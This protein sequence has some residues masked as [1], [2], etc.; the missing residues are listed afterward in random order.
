MPSNDLDQ[1]MMPAGT[2][3]AFRQSCP[4]ACETGSACRNVKHGT[5][6]EI[7][8]EIDAIN[9]VHWYTSVPVPSVVEVFIEEIP[10]AE[11]S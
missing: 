5:S 6:Q 4:T 3:P 11:S 1:V 7:L 9:F 10:N 2:I 8:R